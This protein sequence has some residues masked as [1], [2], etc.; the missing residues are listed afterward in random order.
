LFKKLIHHFSFRI[1][2]GLRVFNLNP[3]FG[4]AF[5]ALVIAFIFVK[6]PNPFYP[7][8]VLSIVL[9]FHWKRKDI[10]FLQKVFVNS[11][12]FIIIAEALAIYA[13]LGSI[14][15]NYHWE[16]TGFAIGASLFLLGFI[17]PRKSVIFTFS[18]NIIPSELFEWKSYLRKYS[19]GAI[20]AYLAFIACA[21][22]PFTLLFSTLFLLEIIG[23]VFEK[24]ENKEMYVAYF[25]TQKLNVKI[26]KNLNILNVLLI[27]ILVVYFILNYQSPQYIF[28][29]LVFVNLYTVLIISNK[30]KNY[31]HKSKETTL[32]MADELL[33]T[34]ST[35]AIIPALVM[36]RKN[37]KTAES[38]IKS[39]VGN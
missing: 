23:S 6:I 31:H 15:K 10:P 14:N 12:R 27:P 16:Q 1:T 38:K 20:F 9:G 39:Y 37:L 18:W 33:F 26:K 32:N 29:Y 19:L 21:Y 8:L 4:F 22:H 7:V 17:Y 30:Y 34:L 2:Q 3:R 28:I 24:N 13:F 36:I 35:F 11:W 25:Q 5:L